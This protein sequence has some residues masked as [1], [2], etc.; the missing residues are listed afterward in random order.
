MISDTNPTISTTPP[1]LSK[2]TD[3]TINSNQENTNPE[4]NIETITKFTSVDEFIENCDNPELKNLYESFLKIQSLQDSFSQKRSEVFKFA[5]D[6]DL[7]VEDL[8]GI[9]SL[10]VVDESEVVKDEASDI[11][12]VIPDELDRTEPIEKLVGDQKESKQQPNDFTTHSE[13]D[14]DK[15]N[16]N[17]SEGITAQ[18][19]SDLEQLLIRLKNSSVSSLPTTE[20]SETHPQTI[21]NMQKLKNPVDQ[22]PQLQKIQ[23]GIES[24]NSHLELLK[25][26]KTYEGLSPEHVEE[27]DE[28]SGKMEGQLKKILSLKSEYEQLV[29]SVPLAS[30]PIIPESASEDLDAPELKKKDI[31]DSYDT[32]TETAKEM[33]MVFDK[34]LE[35]IY[36]L[37]DTAILRN[38]GDPVFLMLVFRALIRVGGDGGKVKREKLGMVLDEILW[39]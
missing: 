35:K 22:D 17:D 8:E 16:V 33:K 31:T 5:D 12:T 9:D 11:R 6:S 4:P 39:E 29:S 18:Q 26:L 25:K 1:S 27:Y 19:E 28:I 37:A 34:N 15:S 13:P 24:I 38:S 23:S 20:R 3:S 21:E 30:R 14:Q 10:D 36:G 32:E 7:D 2:A